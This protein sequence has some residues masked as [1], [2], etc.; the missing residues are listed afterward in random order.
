MSGLKPKI[1][2]RKVP[3]AGP[4]GLPLSESSAGLLTRNS[5]FLSAG[6]KPSLHM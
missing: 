3:K 5:S 6:S 2:L 1:K 4:V